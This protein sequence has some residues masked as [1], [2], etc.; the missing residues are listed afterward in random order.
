MLY[1]L[2]QR[3]ILYSLSPWTKELWHGILSLIK[4]VELTHKVIPEECHI[5]PSIYEYKMNPG[6]LGGLS[7][8][9]P[10]YISPSLIRG[11]LCYLLSQFSFLT[12][13]GIR[14][15][16]E[17]TN[18]LSYI[19][20]GLTTNSLKLIQPLHVVE[21]IMKR[22]ISHSPDLN[23]INCRFRLALQLQVSHP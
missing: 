21:S 8:F 20:H 18:C 14:I 2:S 1:H 23:L 4:F 22:W 7:C 5:P 17:I 6:N 19:H 12:Y 15:F 3:Y 10:V 16:E 9:T 13:T 11:T